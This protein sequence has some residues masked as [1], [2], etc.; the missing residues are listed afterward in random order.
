MVISP[1]FPDEEDQ[2][3]KPQKTDDSYLIKH[4][5]GRK[6]QP[7][8]KDLQLP[9]HARSEN[10]NTTH[11]GSVVGSNSAVELIRRKLDAIYGEKEPDAEQEIAEVSTPAVPKPHRSKHQQF[12]YELSTSGKSLAQIQTEWHNYYVSLPDTAKHEVWREFYA[13]STRQSSAYT[14]YVQQHGAPTAQQA[15]ALPGFTA[16]QH[17]PASLTAQNTPAHHKAT[18]GEHIRPLPAIP[19]SQR[20][21]AVAHIKKNIVDRVLTSEASQRK[22][23]QHFHSLVFGLGTGFLVLVILLF[24][25]FNEMFVAPF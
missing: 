7:I 22:A 2:P 3:K 11:K 5:Q 12:M 18:V 23:K 19:N 16:S 21:R 25:F 24:G 17:I 10:H 20:K 13:N 9:P 6:L 4:R 1:Q 15:P 8:S 14:S